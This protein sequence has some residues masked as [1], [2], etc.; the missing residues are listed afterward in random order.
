MH[1]LYCEAVLRVDHC[2]FLDEYRMIP[3]HGAACWEAESDMHNIKHV[4]QKKNE[5][6]LTL[7]EVFQ[8]SACSF[9]KINE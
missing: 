8:Q 7:M 1:S 4:L 6:E 3:V 2:V 5:L 9:A